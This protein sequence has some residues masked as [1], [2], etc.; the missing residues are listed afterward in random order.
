LASSAAASAAIAIARLQGRAHLRHRR[1]QRPLDVGLQKGAPRR[2]QRVGLAEFPLQ[3]HRADA[4]AV[5]HPGIA[6]VGQHQFGGTT[7]DVHDQVGLLSEAHAGEH[8]QIDQPRLFRPAHQ[9][10]RQAQLLLHRLQKLLAVGRLAHG[11][12]GRRHDLFH[13]VAGRQL[14]VVAQA[15]EGPLDRRRAQV[16]RVGIPLPQ[17]HRGLLGV[18]HAEAAERHVHLG[19]HQV[20]GIGADVDGGHPPAAG[21]RGRRGQGHGGGSR[22]GGATLTPPRKT[23][24]HRG[25]REAQPAGLI[26][27]K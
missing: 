9:V 27:I 13:A 11:T 8:A 26:E 15:A 23:C 12:G 17:A 5:Q 2:R 22:Q 4:R 25:G 16:T 6:A 19:D 18:Q 1:I 21:R 3:P 7:A 20:K 10:H 14:A 24:T